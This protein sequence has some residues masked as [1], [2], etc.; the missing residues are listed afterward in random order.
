MTINLYEIA[1]GDI[2]KGIPRLDWWGQITLVRIQ[3]EET[4]ARLRPTDE[5]A[6][7]VIR[8]TYGPQVSLVSPQ[9]ALEAIQGLSVVGDSEHIFL[10]G[11]LIPY[12]L[13]CT[14]S[15]FR[16]DGTNK[17]SNS[18]EISMWPKRFHGLYRA[19]GFVSSLAPERGY[20]RGIL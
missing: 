19:V 15:S 12:S 20:V 6:R 2:S 13:V 16:E 8:V 9:Q 17:I 11:R 5:F 4:Q 7:S 1:N 10:E 14:A 18:T 3:R